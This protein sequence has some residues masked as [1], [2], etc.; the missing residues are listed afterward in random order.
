[1]SDHEDLPYE[2][3]A[4]L[5][6]LP[7]FASVDAAVAVING[8]IRG[9]YMRRLS[10]LAADN[11]FSDPLVHRIGAALSLQCDRVIALVAVATTPPGS[12]CTYPLSSLTTEERRGLV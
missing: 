2:L 9:R 8:D 11:K 12:V 7:P 10:M 3:A 1:M 6:A 4:E 5:A